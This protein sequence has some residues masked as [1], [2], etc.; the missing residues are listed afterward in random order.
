MRNCSER[1]EKQPASVCRLRIKPVTPAGPSFITLL[2]KSLTLVRKSM[3]HV[4]LTSRRLVLTLVLAVLCLGTRADRGPRPRSGADL[5]AMPFATVMPQTVLWAWEEPEDLRSAPESIGVAYL[6]ETLLLGKSAPAV[7]AITVIK[8]HQPLAV[9]PQAS[10]MAV[11]R[12][13]ALPG[14]QDSPTIREQTAAALAEVSHRPGLRAL[15]FLLRP[16]MPAAMPLS[17]TAL[18]SWCAAGPGSGDW[19]STLPIDEAVPMFFRLGGNARSGDSKSGYPLRD[20]HC[21]GSFGI[22][23]DENWPPLDPHARIYL[24]APRPWTPLQLAALEGVPSGRRAPALQFDYA[25]SNWHSPNDTGLRAGKESAVPAES[26]PEE[27]LQ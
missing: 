14:F 6:A 26:L 10:V 1:V 23:T 15:L 8:R 7:P 19:L 25:R 27:S 18:L 20:A 11:V 22:S 5:V 3:A 12:V 24:F 2:L 9:A 17:M 13:I 21:R 4:Q 16:H